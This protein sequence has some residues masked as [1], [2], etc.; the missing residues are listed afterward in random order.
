[1]VIHFQ[2]GRSVEQTSIA[3]F[4][5]SNV[6]GQYGEG[7]LQTFMPKPPSTGPTAGQVAMR[8]RYVSQEYR[9]HGR[10]HIYIYIYYVCE[11]D[12][13]RGGYVDRLQYD[14][15][16]YSNTL[17]TSVLRI[18]HCWCTNSSN[19]SSITHLV[20]KKT[21]DSSITTALHTFNSFQGSPSPPSIPSSPSDKFVVPLPFLLRP[22]AARACVCLRFTSPSPG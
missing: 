2:T 16:Y 19:S 10:I 14:T 11:L 12:R 22:A 6:S 18:S 13:K 3:S 1:M 7:P 4:H 9:Q 20:G 5:K 17:Y 8:P 21:S 15:R